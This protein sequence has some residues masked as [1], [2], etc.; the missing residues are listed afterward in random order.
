MKFEVQR[1]K[2]YSPVLCTH[3]LIQILHQEKNHIE[4]C[5]MVKTN[6]IM[7][8]AARWGMRQNQRDKLNYI[9]KDRQE[10]HVTAGS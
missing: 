8:K 5:W 2:S 3:W 9:S 7:C 6:I 1:L 10:T 4:M